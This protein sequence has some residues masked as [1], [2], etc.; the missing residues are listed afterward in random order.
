MPWTYYFAIAAGVAWIY[1]SYLYFRSPYKL[2]NESDK[3]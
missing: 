2:K 1:Y 3:N